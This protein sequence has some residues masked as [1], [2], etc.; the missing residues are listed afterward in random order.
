LKD[1]VIAGAVRTPIGTL[2]GVLSELPAR[3]LGTMVVSEAI[4]R[5]G[6]DA[7]RVDELLLGNVIQAGLGLNVARRVALDAGL[8]V[9]STATTVNMACASGLRAVAMAAQAVAAGD[10]SVVVAGGTESMSGT[11]YLLRR[12]RFGY[13]MG[14]GELDDAML[15]DGLTCPIEMYHMAITAENVAEEMGI[16]R[17]EQDLFALESQMRAA[18][19]MERG[20]FQREIAPVEVV[21][22]KGL[23]LMVDTDEHPRPDM[24]LEKLSNLKPAFKKDGTVT[25]GNAS[26]INDGAAAMVVTRL[27]TAE[28]MGVRPMARIVDYAWVG[29]EPRVMGLGPVPAV[30]RVLEKSGL[31]L[32]DIDLIELNEAFAAQSLGVIRKLGMDPSIVN[33]NGGA[34]ALGHAIGCSGARILVTLLHEM[35]RRQ[36][37]YGLATLCIGGGQGAAM[38]LENLAR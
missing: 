21:R 8:V 26:G 3:Q 19:A 29:V 30:H 22:R 38:V 12:A 33:V 28:E 36:V 1:V 18:R 9:E 27:G 17:S 7:A 15:S 5:A 23:P 34:I 31:K 35:A 16:A 2:G 4:R 10:A 14:P 11:P 37:R 32:F 6:V 13:R 24:T 25:A 20:L